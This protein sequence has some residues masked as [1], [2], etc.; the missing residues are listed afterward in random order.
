M[1]K[2]PL[3]SA[4]IFK[5]EP[6]AK[7]RTTDAGGADADTHIGPRDDDAAVGDRPPRLR[8][9]MA[10]DTTIH[11]WKYMQRLDNTKV[12]LL[13]AIAAVICC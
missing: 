1:G 12:M 5:A 4:I 3:K 13:I 6:R 9:N 11:C 7:L 8:R 2:P 10:T